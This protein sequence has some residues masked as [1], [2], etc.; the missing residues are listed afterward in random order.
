MSKN[1]KDLY[2]KFL[3]VL[4]AVLSPVKPQKVQE[5]RER[6]R[7]REKKLRPATKDIH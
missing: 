3:P 1:K 5:A 4:D 7:E 6:E 2:G